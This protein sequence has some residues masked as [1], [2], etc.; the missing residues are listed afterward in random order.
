ML[1]L[2]QHLFSDTSDDIS[3]F[4]IIREYVPSLFTGE[5]NALILWVPSYDEVWQ[6]I[7]DRDLLS[8]PGP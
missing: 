8:A 6:T 7:F 4:S 1:F 5:E 2:Y 3:D